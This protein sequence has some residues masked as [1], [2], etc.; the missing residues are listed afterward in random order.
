MRDLTTFDHVITLDIE[1]FYSNDYSLRKMTMTEYIQHPQFKLHSIAIKDR[2]GETRYYDTDHVPLAIEYLKSLRN[3]AMVGQN[4]QFD[5][6]ALNW[7]YGIKPDFYYDTMSMGKGFWPTES[8]SLKELALR[9]FPNDLSKRKGEDLINFLGVETLT[10]EQ[11]IVMK[12]YN[13]QDVDLTWD[14]FKSLMA[15]G[16]PEEE[17]YQIHMVM[18]MYVEPMFVIDRP[19]LE[20]AI[21]ED[22]TAT[23]AAIEKALALVKLEAPPHFDLPYDKKLFSSNQRFA[24]LLKEVFDVEPPIKLNAKGA[25]TFAFGKRDVQFIEMRNENPDLVHIFDARELVKSTIAASRAATMLRCSEPSATNPEG[26]LP[27]PLRYYGA[28]TGRM[29]G[30]LMADTKIIVRAFDGLVVSI[31]LG[32]LQDSDMVWDGTEF[33]HHGGLQFKGYQG[34]ISHDGITGTE[35]HKVFTKDGTLTLAQSY[36]ST[37]PIMDCRAPEDWLHRIDG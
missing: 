25:S 20:S 35:D 22:V 6:A 23:D 12:R 1:T 28:A 2:D 9:I 16:F 31:P 4:T 13:I 36:V 26:R 37:T 15:F 24:R 34:V 19:L 10:P 5:A 11:H 3:W 30:C 21:E 29:A 17:L 27:V 33:V 8:S 14:I 7:H 32:A 18:R